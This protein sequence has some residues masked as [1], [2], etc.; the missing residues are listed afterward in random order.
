MR[1]Q[2]YGCTQKKYCTVKSVE[3]P[4]FLGVIHSA[5]EVVVLRLEDTLSESN[6]IIIE[7]GKKFN[8]HFACVDAKGEPVVSGE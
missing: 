5:A 7:Q 2:C 3:I 6:E 4:C 1:A 8:I